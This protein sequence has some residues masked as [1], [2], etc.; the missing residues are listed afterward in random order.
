MT[1]DRVR[2][3]NISTVSPPLETNPELAPIKLSFFDVKF[4]F[5]FP[6]TSV[7][8]YQTDVSLF[9]SFVLKLK[10][11]LSQ[12]LKHF[13]PIAGKLIYSL[14]STELEIDCT[15]SSVVFIEAESDIDMLELAGEEMHNIL[16]FRSLVPEMDTTKL[17]AP[18]LSVQV[19]CFTGGGVAIGTSIHHVAM[20]GLSAW[21]FFRSWAEMCRTGDPNVGPDIWCDRSLFR[22][23]FGLEIS[24]HYLERVAPA[25]PE[26]PIFGA[27]IPE[28]QLIRRTFTLTSTNTHF[29]KTLAMHGNDN[30]GVPI[31]TFVAVS[32]HSWVCNLRAKGA[33]NEEDCCLMLAVDQRR[34]FAPLMP[35]AEYFGNCITFCIVRAKGHQVYGQDG[36]EFSVRAIQKAIREAVEEPLKDCKKW[37]ELFFNLPSVMMNIAGS[38]R[39]DVYK[40]DFGLG[41][42]RRMEIVS[43][44]T[45]GF[46]G[47][48]DAREG[49]GVQVSVTLSPLHMDKFASLFLDGLDGGKMKIRN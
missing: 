18:L 22:D 7:L 19:T 48:V 33:N 20:D 40:T 8:F 34:H 38:P 31:S 36:F 11:S 42:P 43:M 49:G 24:R 32:A 21:C 3:T 17:P 16:V 27:P 39:F 37:A 12:A 47:L 14:S 13:R 15:D 23:S 41:R 44:N 4:I 10:K 46:V 30:G 28:P 2:L 9:P 25:L 29:L 26:L 1:T 45:E 35:K 6:I 5:V